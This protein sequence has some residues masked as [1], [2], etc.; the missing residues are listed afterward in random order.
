MVCSVITL[1]DVCNWKAGTSQFFLKLF[2]V[3][4]ILRKL[5][6]QSKHKEKN[7][8]SLIVLSHLLHLVQ[9]FQFDH[10][11]NYR[12]GHSPWPW[13]GLLLDQH[14]EPRST[15][16]VWT[17]FIFKWTI[18]RFTSDENAI[19]LNLGP[20]CRKQTKTQCIVCWTLINN[21]TKTF[22]GSLPIKWPVAWALI[23]MVLNNTNPFPTSPHH[24]LIRHLHFRRGACHLQSNLVTDKSTFKTNWRR[25]SDCSVAYSVLDY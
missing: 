1:L 17:C 12:C 6:L 11:Q 19:G 25:V 23:N 2:K 14:T 20:I 9:T 3:G 10:D 7:K 15:W 4:F 16:K 13:P 21:F 22:W 8:R 18:V 24:R 5:H